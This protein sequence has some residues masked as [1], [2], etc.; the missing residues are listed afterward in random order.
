MESQTA[1]INDSVAYVNI[2]IFYSNRWFAFRILMTRFL[3]VWR[4]SAIDKKV[5][6][7]R[8]LRSV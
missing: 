3:P 4:T 2:W 5:T 8:R 1:V 7:L 6:K